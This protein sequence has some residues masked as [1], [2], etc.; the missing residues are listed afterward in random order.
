MDGPGSPEVMSPTELNS[1]ADLLAKGAACNV[2]F[3]N[4]IDTESLTGPQAI[5]KAIK[6]TIDLQASLKSTV[7]HFKVSSQGI[8]LTDINRK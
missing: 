6:C 2:V 4:T 7:V 3:I 1:A 5:A 8:T